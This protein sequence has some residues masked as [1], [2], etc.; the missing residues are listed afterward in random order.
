MPKAMVGT[1]LALLVL[2]LA[3]VTAACGWRPTTSTTGI[4][5]DEVERFL[6]RGG[7]LMVHSDACRHCQDAMPDFE[8]C[9]LDV[10][11]AFATLDGERYPSMTRSLG[12]VAYPTIL[13][14]VSG[15][16]VAFDEPVTVRGLHAFRSSGGS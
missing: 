13:R 8:A 4:R 14:Q 3:L 12:V 7:V 5:A 11:G 1:L 9:A 15:R 16:I 2:L 6:A 10:P